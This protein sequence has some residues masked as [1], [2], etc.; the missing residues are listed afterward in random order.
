MILLLGGSGYIG[1]AFQRELGRRGWRYRN[2][3]RREVNYTQF[4]TLWK[5]LK[6]HRP[7]FVINCAGFTGRPNVDACE[8]AKADA[9]LGNVVLPECI[10]HACAACQVPW[11]QVSSGCV[12]NG[13]KI[14]TQESVRIEEDLSRSSFRD[15]IENHPG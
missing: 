3:S 8:T 10:A 11:G 15:R 1:E 14:H 7:D 5:F 6:E 12:Y 4:E 9:L 2:L 13:A